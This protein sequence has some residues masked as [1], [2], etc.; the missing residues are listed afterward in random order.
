MTAQVN[1]K[2]IFQDFLADQYQNSSL[3]DVISGATISHIVSLFGIYLSKRRREKPSEGLPDPNILQREFY[4][5]IQDK[6]V[7][8]NVEFKTLKAEPAKPAEPNRQ[9]TTRTKIS[10]S[11]PATSFL[12]RLFGRKK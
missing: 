7:E 8:L 11:E 12:S 9:R 10:K 5:F 4:V 1:N 6:A 2:K 3:R